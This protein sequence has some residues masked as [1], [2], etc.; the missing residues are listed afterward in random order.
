MS[1]QQMHKKAKY[2]IGIVLAAG[3]F[4]CSADSSENDTK[5]LVT[6]ASA[7]ASSNNTKMDVVK[8]ADVKT[9]ANQLMTLTGQILYQQMEGGFYGFVANNGDKYMPSGLK[10]EYRK[11]GLIVELKVE[12]MP[13]ILTTQQFGDVVNVLEIKVL[14]A[15]K[16]SDTNESM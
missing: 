9:E 2:L 5:T 6:T 12:L 8:G 4:A 1:T 15:S 16:V 14:D 10:S 11:N 3:L 7:Q 13:D